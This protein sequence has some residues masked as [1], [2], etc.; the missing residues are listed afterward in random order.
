VA[1]TIQI[2]TIFFEGGRRAICAIFK[3]NLGFM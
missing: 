1:T 3:K 2:K